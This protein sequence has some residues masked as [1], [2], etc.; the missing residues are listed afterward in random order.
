MKIVI[1]LGGNALIKPGEKGTPEEQLRNIE[2]SVDGIVKLITEGHQV[3]VTHGNGPQAGARL[4][5]NEMAATEVFPDPLVVCVADTQGSMGY[6]IEQGLV[7]RLTKAGVRPRIATLV[8]QIEVNPSD[9]AFSKPTKP[10]G[11]FYTQEKA[12]AKMKSGWK[13]VEDAGRGY[14]R[15]VPSPMPLRMVNPEALTSLLDHGFTVITG[16]GGGIPVYRDKTGHLAG[17]DAVIDKD[18]ASV[19]IARSIQADIVVILTGVEKVAINFKSGNPTWIDRMSVREAKSYLA[20]G[21]FPAG[22]MGPKIQAAID[23]AEAFRDRKVIITSESKLTEALAGT[24][25][26]V[27]ENG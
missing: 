22:S 24:T 14:R 27:I 5:R 1:A 18:L 2:N 4:I 11:P 17:I 20:Q 9:P 8:T 7:N 19:M 16:G 23:F 21:E 25:G 6:M 12:I 13:M 10:V 26:T 3:V 15:V